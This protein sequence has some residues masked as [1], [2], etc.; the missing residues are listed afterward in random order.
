M[1]IFDKITERV[2][3]ILDEVMLPEGVRR[4]HER[5]ARALDAGDTSRALQL[6]QPTLIEYPN[7]SRTHHLIG[8]CHYENEEWGH[9]IA[10]FERALSIKEYPQS[11]LFAGM[12]AEKLGRWADVHR[13]FHQALTVPE[14]LPFAFDLHFGLGRA[15]RA[16][17]RPD[18]AAK[19]L[20]SA[21]K[22]QPTHLD[23]SRALIG[24]LLDRGNIDEATQVLEALPRSSN[25][26]YQMIAA[27]VAERRGE[28]Q[29]AFEAYSS[30]A[31]EL[32][33]HRTPARLGAARNALLTGN[34]LRAAE[35]VAAASPRTDTEIVEHAILHG[36]VLE[37]QGRGFDAR[38]AFER[39]LGID[40]D[41]PDALLGMG[42]VELMT[43]DADAAAANFARVLRSPDVARPQEALFGIA[44]CHMLAGDI[45]G[46]RHLFEEALKH[47]GRLAPQI[48]A[49]LGQAALDVGDSAAAIVHLRDALHQTPDGSERD[50]VQALLDRALADLSPQW[51]LPSALEEPVQLTEALDALTQYIGR[52]GRLADFLAPAQQLRSALN[53]PLSLAIVG[54]FNAGKSTIVN[55][56]VGE[57][58][59]PVGVVP[60][61]AQTGIVRWGPRKAARIV[62]LDGEKKE[63]SLDEARK[64]MKTDAE[65]IERIEFT[66]PHPDLRLVHY[67]DTPGFNALVERHEVVAA[68]ALRTAE[69]ILWVMDA[70]QVLSQTEFDR[71]EDVPN[72]DERL[73]VVIN[74]IDRLGPPGDRDDEVDHLMEY[75]SENLDGRL[76]GLFPIS[77]R[78]AA[79]EDEGTR[80]ASGFSEFQEFLEQRVI[81][82]AGRIKTVEGTRQ[83][84]ALVFT[85][86]AFQ[87]G[88]LGRY[89]QLL[90]QVEEIEQWLQASS[91]AVTKS[92]SADEV[93][94]LR[95]WVDKA[96]GDVAREIGDALRPTGTWTGRLG[97]VEEDRA[98]VLQLVE[99][100]F[101]RL[102]ELSWHRTSGSLADV[103]RDL[104]E[105]LD[106]V[107]RALT[108][109]DARA[110]ERRL[111][112]FFDETR[113]LGSLWEERVYGALLARARG[114]IDTAG[115]STL[116]TIVAAR[117]DR[118]TWP[119]SLR[120][121][122]P[123]IDAEFQRS[124]TEWYAAFFEAALR[125]C[126][127]V[128][129]DLELLELEATQRYDVGPLNDLLR[130][131]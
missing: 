12:A 96:L 89:G 70:N 57:Q 5:A 86:D 32:G 131:D 52:D 61:T 106:P 81:Q 9:A 74:K 129:R 14:P 98:F 77:A 42:R 104:A 1:S 78:D 64:A 95:E 71:I 50:A 79:S 55:E 109:A 119:R 66:H 28:H 102:L 126:E 124:I 10:A 48:L 25:P 8:L 3:D 2:G 108:R 17:G 72:S 128:R 101:E 47:P 117:G 39:A 20:R 73:V 100:R 85:L 41:H 33:T 127:R 35:L 51:E 19:E 94:A 125:L 49:F 53:A 21:L 99:E 60:T 113:V 34:E 36:K 63:L 118:T 45:A 22:L 115:E 76:A 67:W 58:V 4:M 15:Y 27:E 29:A 93:V 43:K 122:L 88:L 75:V 38:E 65:Q 40:P 44:R 6:L 46:A 123:D 110:L 13:H 105:K 69:A 107:L 16:L 56:L 23:A 130:R 91:E 7:V 97:L 83:L 84:E 103:E 18:K 30:A 114:R 112:G 87:R 62:Y 26:Q 111:E 92:R 59:F 68:E 121:L 82:R 90:E 24:A 37:S 120:K 31:A 116:D 11:H 80:E 54:E